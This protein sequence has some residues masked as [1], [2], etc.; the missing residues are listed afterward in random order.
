MSRPKHDPQSAP[1]DKTLMH[2]GLLT[3]SYSSWRAL[4]SNSMSEDV[5]APISKMQASGRT[6]RIRGVERTSKCEPN[7]QTKNMNPPRPTN[8]G[9]EARE[10]RGFPNTGFS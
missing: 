10:K 3:R 9:I 7:D 5:P 1:P 6:T 8:S 2:G 4:L